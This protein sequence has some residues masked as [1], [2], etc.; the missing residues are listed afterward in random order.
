[1][2]CIL[3]DAMLPPKVRFADI[4]VVEELTAGTDLDD[5]AD[6]QHVCAVGNGE[7]LLGILLNEKDGRAEGVDLLYHIKDGI[8]VQGRE[9]HAGLVE[10][11]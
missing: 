8:Y 2:H 10:E 3:A 7:R 1:M 6:L 5:I 9:A 11:Q 4:L